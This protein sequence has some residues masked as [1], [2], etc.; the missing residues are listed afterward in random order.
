MPSRRFWNAGRILT[1]AAM[2]LMMAPSAAPARVCDSDHDRMPDRW[3]RANGLRV[4]TKDARRD[5]DRDSLS[6]IGEYR[7][8]T[9]PRSPEG[10]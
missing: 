3:E 6:N 1:L 8:G 2:A 10:P 5:A 9:R 4:K 7:S